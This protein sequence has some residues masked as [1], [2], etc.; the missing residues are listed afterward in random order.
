MCDPE[1][2]AQLSSELHS[3][4]C[5]VHVCSDLFAKIRSHSSVTPDV[6]CQINSLCLR[7]L[8]DEIFLLLLSLLFETAGYCAAGWQCVSTVDNLHDESVDFQLSK[9]ADYDQVL[10]Q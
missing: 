4:E 10:Y 9:Q 3:R 8:L 6:R 5:P 7:Q 1:N 2:L